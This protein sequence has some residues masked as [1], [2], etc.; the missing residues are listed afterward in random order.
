MERSLIGHVRTNAAALTATAT[1]R[2]TDKLAL[3]TQQR[4]LALT[5]AL[6]VDMAVAVGQTALETSHP[7]QISLASTT[8]G[9]A[10]PLTE[11]QLRLATDSNMKLVVSQQGRDAATAIAA[12]MGAVV[13]MDVDV[14]LSSV[15]GGGVEEVKVG[16]PSVAT[17]TCV[18]YDG[19]PVD[20]G[21]NDIEVVV[22]AVE[23]RT[24]G[25]VGAAGGM[26]AAM[27]SICNSMNTSCRVL[28]DL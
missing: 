14:E 16:V 5:D 20:V 22:T 24:G 8:V 23:R 2:C 11:A 27:A 1:Q 15:D 6:H 13:T 25:G 4:A 26:C 28:D 17:I 19:A 9:A 21:V 3:L 10:R 7:I 12:C 18:G